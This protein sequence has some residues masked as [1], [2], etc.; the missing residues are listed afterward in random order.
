M[1]AEHR[2]ELQTNTLADHIGRWIQGLRQG[3]KA[4]PTPSTLVVMIFVF[5]ALVVFVGWRYYSSSEQRKRSHLWL[6]LDEARSLADVEEIAEKNP[7][8]TPGQV[9]QFERARVLLQKGSQ[10]LFSDISRPEA[11]KNLEEAEKLYDDLIPQSQDRPL[12]VQEAMLGVAKCMEARGELEEA[13]KAYED[14]AKVAE[15]YPHSAHGQVAAEQLKQLDKPEVQKFYARLNEL[16]NAKPK[17]PASIPD[18]L[19]LK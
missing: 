12:L 13:R 11:L 18:W 2:K 16:A 3:M 1:K 5:L 19:P 14:L 4:T 6:E 9:A 15:K 10:N 7:K 17:P 8:T